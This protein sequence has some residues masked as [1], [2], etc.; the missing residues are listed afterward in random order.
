MSIY[1]RALLSRS[2][3]CGRPECADEP[4]PASGCV[5]QCQGGILAG[6]A[7]PTSATAAALRTNFWSQDPTAAM[8]HPAEAMAQ[9]QRASSMSLACTE[10]ILALKLHG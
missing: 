3:R 4:A 9:R 6:V 1:E 2:S 10:P 8:Q 7:R 5:E